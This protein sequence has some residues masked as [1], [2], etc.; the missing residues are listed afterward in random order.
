MPTYPLEDTYSCA[1]TV[2]HEKS[3]SDSKANENRAQLT[4]ASVVDLCAPLAR[5][6]EGV[7]LDA[8]QGLLERRVAVKTSSDSS[9]RPQ[10]SSEQ[11]AQRRLMRE[12]WV[13]GQLEHPHIVP[14]HDVRFDGEGRAYVVL[15]KV[16]GRAWAELLNGTA[17]YPPSS[18]AQRDLEDWNL[19]TFIKVCD[20]VQYAH[21]KGILHRDI[22]PENILIGDDGEVYLAD[23]GLA[24]SLLDRSPS[25]LP[26]AGGLGEFAGTPAYMAPEML[27]REPLDSRSDIYL[28][29]ATLYHVLCG[30][31]PHADS[32]SQIDVHTSSAIKPM[33]S[34]VPE[35]LRLIL[36]RA[37][38]LDPESRYQSASEFRLA[39]Q[40]YRRDKEARK[41]QQE[42]ERKLEEL[43]GF[44]LAARL[45][46]RSGARRHVYR[47][48]GAVRFGYRQTLR[49]LPHNTAS[50]EGLLQ[51]YDALIAFELQER[52]PDAADA[53]IQEAKA[54]FSDVPFL[55]HSDRYEEWRRQ[56]ERAR[57][58]TGRDAQALKAA[59][60]L[61]LD[62]D[63]RVGRHTRLF[64]CLVLGSVGVAAPML[65]MGLEGMGY[66]GLNRAG[67]WLMPLVFLS[68]F[69]GF[70]Y[71]VRHS[72]MKS[73]VDRTI[74]TAVLIALSSQFAVL[75]HGVGHG[76]HQDTVRTELLLIWG[77]IALLIAA[78]VDRRL[79]FATLG[80]LVA[81]G[82]AV[83]VPHVSQWA[84]ICSNVAL[85]GNVLF[86]WS[87]RG[88]LRFLRENG[89]KDHFRAVRR[90]RDPGFGYLANER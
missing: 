41:V 50:K 18:D 82:I 38:S 45:R 1:P 55:K 66:P 84:L 10:A 76:L 81:F 13:L 35:A 25:Q 11:S 19:R 89:L 43:R 64:L 17:D 22:K 57:Y 12:A 65:A 90:G 78:I 52:D 86:L 75:V 37:M 36:T 83:V 31:P 85:L 77:V 4:L 6:G 28:L 63:P 80:Y 49:S 67:L 9:N 7:V 27:L 87:R 34:H 33:P 39:V 61:A 58:D 56:V 59:R 15:R 23:W 68:L 24:A 5:G 3:V 62:R 54:D 88:D 73:W 26:F 71:W 29:G 51:A 69:F 2:L 48:F 8:V 60:A 21:R 47:L 46:P 14:I 30:S 53:A 20:A 16:E 40:E 74:G 32:R 79:A 70:G 42:A 44:V 72:L